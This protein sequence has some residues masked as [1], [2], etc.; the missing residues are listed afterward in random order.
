MRN[1]AY[2][3]P[4]SRH[5][6]V[7]A[8]RLRPADLL[9]LA[10]SLIAT[11][12]FTASSAQQHS[13]GASRS[14]VANIL[15]PVVPGPVD[16][17]RKPAQ[18]FDIALGLGGYLKQLEGRRTFKHSRQ[19]YLHSHALLV[20]VIETRDWVRTVEAPS[21]LREIWYALGKGDHVQ[22]AQDASDYLDDVSLLFDERLRCELAHVIAEVWT[23]KLIARLPD[24]YEFIKQV[25]PHRID[26]TFTYRIR[27]PFVSKASP[28]IYLW[29][30]TNDKAWLSDWSP[31]GLEAD[32]VIQTLL[33]STVR[34]LGRHSADRVLERLQEELSA[35]L[36]RS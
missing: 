19:A 33:R 20:D 35:C 30:D 6:T 3:R 5:R 17:R 29:F 28:A 12:L 32:R 7:I 13:P 31:S 14:S 24:Q 9:A 27:L 18:D 23:D 10:C 25:E 4:G 11:L 21:M 22:S 15:G 8:G 34:A 26:P 1:G 2:S 16:V 36:T